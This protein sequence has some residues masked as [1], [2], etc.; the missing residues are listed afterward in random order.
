MTASAYWHLTIN[1][2]T[3]LMPAM[4]IHLLDCKSP[5]PL[6]RQLGN[7]K[8]QLCMLI[9]PELRDTYWGADFAYR[10]FQRARAKLSEDSTT[11]ARA[12]QASISQYRAPDAVVVPLT[13]ESTVLSQSQSN[14]HG[15][16]SYPSLDDILTPGFSLG[17]MQYPFWIDG[18]GV[19]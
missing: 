16:S 1:R 3:T 19:R 17:A 13:P 7:L 11:Q 6:F 8:F 15:Y 14:Y 2:I 4:Q 18:Q 12:D 9:L 10:M 5:I